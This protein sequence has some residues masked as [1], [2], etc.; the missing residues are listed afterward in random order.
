MI[1]ILLANVKFRRSIYAVKD[2]K[3]GEKL[4]KDN[5]QIIRPGFGLSPKYYEQVLSKIA[6]CDIAYGVSLK[7][8]DVV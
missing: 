5:I 2:I 6:S 3:K 8:T 1:G 4:T 7:W